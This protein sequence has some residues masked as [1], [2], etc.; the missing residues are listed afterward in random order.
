MLVLPADDEQSSHCSGA[1]DKKQPALS[2]QVLLKLIG[3]VGF[4][5]SWQD[6][7]FDIGHCHDRELETFGRMNG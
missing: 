4:K 3:L 7:L 6:A 5:E 2:E 1:A